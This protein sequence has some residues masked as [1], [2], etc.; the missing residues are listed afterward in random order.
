[1]RVKITAHTIDR[2]GHRM[3]SVFHQ[4]TLFAIGAATVWAAGWTYWELFSRHTH[5]AIGDLLLLF[6]YLEIGAMVGIYFKTNH[7]PVRFLLYIAITA[8]TRHTIDVMS[9]Q[10]V[11]I[12]ELLATGATTVATTACVFLIKYSSHHYPN[13]RR[14]DEVS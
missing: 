5:A 4:L 8:L 3:V 7:L 10:P 11:N 12:W 1:M 6:I 13:D 2:L 9:H 14:E